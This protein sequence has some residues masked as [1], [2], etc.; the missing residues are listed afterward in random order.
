MKTKIF[1][2]IIAILCLSMIFVAC[3]KQQPCTEHKDENN[4]LVCDVCSEKVE[5]K[6]ECTT[7][8]TTEATTEPP[9]EPCE[10]HKDDNADKVCDVCKYA[11]AYIPELVAPEKETHANM[12]VSPI[13]ESAD[14]SDFINVE[15]EDKVITSTQKMEGSVVDS[16]YN[17]IFNTQIQ[18][19]AISNEEGVVVKY[20]LRDAITLETI[21]SVDTSDIYN[22]NITMYEYYF[23]VSRVSEFEA[24]Y[25]NYTYSAQRIG[26]VYQWTFVEGEES[27]D[28]F[29]YNNV[30]L[31]EHYSDWR[32]VYL[33]DSKE[34]V[35]AIDAETRNVIH[36]EN[37]DSLIMRPEF[38]RVEGNYGYI[39]ET[40][41]ET[42]YV[43]DLEQW[44]SCV[45][46][47]KFP[48]YEIRDNWFVLGN[49]NVLIQTR[50]RLANDAVNFDVLMNGSKYD[51]VY[52]LVDVQSK[53]AKTVE[54]GYDIQRAE[55]LTKSGIYVD[56]AQN[57]FVVY[58]IKNDRIDTNDEKYLIVDNDL[59]I[60][61]DVT[62][63]VNKNGILIADGLFLGELSYE[64]T[65]ISLDKIFDL[66][67]KEIT[68]PSSAVICGNYIIYKNAIYNF[69]MN[70]LLDPY[71]DNAYMHVEY[72][73]T[74]V[75][76]TKEIVDEEFNVTYAY[77]YFDPSAQD[78]TPMKFASNSIIVNN[79]DD[80]FVLRYEVVATGDDGLEHIVYRYE[81]R[82]EKNQVILTTDSYVW[83]SV[84]MGDYV[85]IYLSNGEVY[86]A[87]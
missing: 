16:R 2:L 55:S 57:L 15:F 56:E 6:T 24:S 62:D 18:K 17:Y 13:P 84:N 42:L 74:Y 12:E 29:Y 3:D 32:I 85:V 25:S 14:L 72:R 87:K 23:E 47:Y 70:L 51:L 20:L 82:N 30:R 7:E 22:V 8:I 61:C 10:T 19:V 5:P 58:P 49:G 33:I 4:D 79:N 50:V 37:I 67:G 39:Y 80:L 66:A 83:N 53:E 44:I 46:T 78:A 86:I 43:Y 38:D 64:N 60:K 45:M 9:V 77:Y 1:T 73:D 21:F 75:L 69:E 26:D 76:L 40:S 27:L 34:M 35:Y 41:V 65:S 28:E 52:T 59:T 71:K 11:L 48:S 36:A 31:S 81:V 63:F 54:F 68:L